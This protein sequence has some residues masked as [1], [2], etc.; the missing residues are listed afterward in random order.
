[1]TKQKVSISIIGT[2][3]TFFVVKEILRF[4]TG[5]FAYSVI[6]GWHTTI[7]SSQTTLTILTILLLVLTLVVVGLYKIIFRI[8]WTLWTRIEK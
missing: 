8:V 6:P 4:I 1:M 5:D 3:L 2:I 7:F